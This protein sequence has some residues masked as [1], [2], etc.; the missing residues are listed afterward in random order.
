MSTALAIFVKTPEYSPIKTRLA[1]GIGAEQAVRFHALA[2]A[3]VAAVA[4]AATPDI[5]PYWAVAEP[6]AL[7]HPL[8][9]DLPTVWQ[10]RGGLG[11]RLDSICAQLQERHGRV[12]LIGADAPQLTVELLRSAL[13][14]L[15]DPHTPLVLGPAGDGG[16]WLFGTRVAIPARAWRAPRYSSADTI[17]DLRQALA[18][19]GNIA[20]L[21]MLN[22]VDTPD[23]LLQL[24]QA[25]DALPAL[26]PAQQAL[27]DWLAARSGRKRACA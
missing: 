6:E 11:A 9:A 12:L 5:T 23:D 27:R 2:A 17:A 22:D 7:E 25:L 21:P 18:P 24:A 8:W 4:K 26:L 20:V 10:G 14:A 19:L 13:S 16:F 3:A 1:A 15:D